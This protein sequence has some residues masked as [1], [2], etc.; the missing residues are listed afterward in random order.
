MKC[1]KT[2]AVKQSVVV[3]LPTLGARTAVMRQGFPTLIVT[4]NPEIYINYNGYMG[5]TKNWGNF[6][7]SKMAVR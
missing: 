4:K 5:K 6:V 2:S 3:S 7:A 1:G